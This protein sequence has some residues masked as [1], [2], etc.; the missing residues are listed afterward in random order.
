MSNTQKPEGRLVEK[1]HGL[2]PGSRAISPVSSQ[3]NI[4]HDTGS[5]RTEA[6]AASAP[7]ASLVS[8]IANP[9]RG[10]V[11][12]AVTRPF[13]VIGTAIDHVKPDPEV[14]RN[15]GGQPV[16]RDHHSPDRVSARMKYTFQMTWHG[17]GLAL[18]K[19]E[20]LL[21]GPPLKTPIGA[22][23]VLINVTNSDELIKIQAVVDNKDVME[24]AEERNG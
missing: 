4:V 14:V 22:V 18:K 12:F 3:G 7:N 11:N 16:D 21:A 15:S 17:V 2:T 1:L 20:R 23:N 5:Q 10:E 8:A 13:I 24:S 19:V 9:S 6:I